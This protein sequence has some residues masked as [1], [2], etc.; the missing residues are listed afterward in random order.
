[1][2]AASQRTVLARELAALDD[3]RRGI[4]DVWVGGRTDVRPVAVRRDFPAGRRGGQHDERVDR[5]LRRVGG[6]ER[7][8]LWIDRG[9]CGQR[10]P[11]AFAGV[12]GGAAAVAVAPRRD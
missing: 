2:V 5:S 4:V 10:V 7:G 9:V 12:A 11:A 8:N 6:R 1:M 3:E